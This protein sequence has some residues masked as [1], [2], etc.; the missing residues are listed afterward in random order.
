LQTVVVDQATAFAEFQTTVSAKFGDAFSSVHT[1]SDA[2]AT[3]DG[4]AAA[5]FAVTLNVDGYATG[6]NLINGGAGT[7]TFTI[8]ADKF[9]V[10]LPG[11]NGNTPY[12]LFTTGLVAGVP[13]VGI[14]GNLILDGTIVTSMIHAGA[15]TA[16][17]IALRAAPTRPPSSAGSVDAD[18]LFSQID[19]PNSAS[20]QTYT[21]GNR[22][23][24][25]S[26]TNIFFGNEGNSH[27]SLTV[28]ELMG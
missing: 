18:F 8:V 23:D 13:S 17:Q 9:Q 1:V 25:T 24:G 6:F 7:S 22:G 11:F 26:P 12:S 10:H 5:E 27:G 15:I 2:V 21:I 20:S 28:Q 4:Y 14:Q 16:I 3:L 19:L